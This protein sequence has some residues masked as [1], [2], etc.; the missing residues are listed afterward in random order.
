MADT[1]PDGSFWPGVS[2]VTP[3]YNQ[4]E[5][6]EETIRSVL[7]QGYPNLEYIIMDGG[8]TDNSVDIVKKYEPWLASWVSEPDNGQS[9]AINKGFRKATGKVL[10]WLN[11][12]DFFQQSAVATLVELRRRHKD[13]VGWVGACQEISQEGSPI[14]E[15]RKPRVGNKGQL[16]NWGVEAFFCQPSCFFDSGLFTAVGGLDERL[17]YAMDLDLW[18]RLSEHGDFA[19]TDEV[20]SYYRYYASAKTF[21]DDS[22]REAEVI[23]SNFNQGM[24][25]VARTRLE[26]HVSLALDKMSLSGLLVYLARRVAHGLW[27]LI[28]S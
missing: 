13:C 14:R 25:E 11:S 22:M 17:H 5:F 7:L 6:I 10:A 26:Y 15:A 16:G 12:D 2:I 18:L 3:S 20:V 24:P 28:R 1:M 4:G 9:Q 8:S 21:R 27:H 19:S 23:A